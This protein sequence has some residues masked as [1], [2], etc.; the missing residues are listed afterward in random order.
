[1]AKPLQAYRVT[2]LIA[3]SLLLASCILLILVGLYPR[4]HII[5]LRVTISNPVLGNLRY[6]VTRLKLESYSTTLLN[7]IEHVRNV[8]LTCGLYFFLD[9]AFLFRN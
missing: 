8:R 3:L 2:S 5:S 4:H 9:S 1:M 7:L 6:M